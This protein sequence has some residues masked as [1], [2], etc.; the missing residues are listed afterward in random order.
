[1]SGNIPLEFERELVAKIKA[2]DANAFS[3][4]FEHYHSKV[5]RFCHQ[6]VKSSDLADEIVQEVFIK[7]WKQKNDLDVY[8][9]FGGFLF[10][11]A[12]NQTID[13]LR[14]QI[15]EISINE[16]ISDNLI[17]NNI[18]AEEAMIYDDLKKIISASVSK[19]P[20]Q[21]Q[22]IFRLSREDGLTHKEI[23]AQ[24]GISPNTVKVNIF[25]SLKELR[26]L[27]S[28]FNL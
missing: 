21:R 6:F 12:K 14:S 26:H 1:M 28:Q 15:S 10:K 5:F 22:R 27:V 23:S 8:K 25:K 9:S 11:V 4:I 19:M 7:V 18:Q 20:E 2:G 13:H 17:S 24:L 16:S 3:R